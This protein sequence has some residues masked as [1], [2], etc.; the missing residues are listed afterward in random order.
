MLRKSSQVLRSLYSLS[1]NMSFQKTKMQ[2]ALDQVWDDTSQQWPRSLGNDHKQE[3]VTSMAARI[4]HACRHLAGGMKRK[5]MPRWVVSVLGDEVANNVCK[6]PAEGQE[7]DEH[8]DVDNGE[9]LGEECGESEELQEDWSV[10]PDET[11]AAASHSAPGD[12]DDVQHAST[13]LAPRVLKAKAGLVNVASYASAQFFS[14]IF[15][16]LQMGTK[17]P[18]HP[19]PVLGFVARPVSP[20]PWLGY[21]ISPGSGLGGHRSGKF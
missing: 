13:P 6:R 16:N 20:Q 3:W 9:D 19:E 21:G 1:S 11:P 17:L 15:R 7:V 5:P 8:F 14:Y 4:R 10:E 2:S 18:A 12:P